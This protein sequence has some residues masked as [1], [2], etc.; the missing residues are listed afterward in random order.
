MLFDSLDLQSHND[1]TKLPSIAF[2]EKVA[3]LI[4]ADYRA[5]GII[6]RSVSTDI[7]TEIHF[8]DNI[9]DVRLPL[10]FVS[11]V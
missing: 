10:W 8:S 9:A 7:V 4:T 11:I 3:D 1:S 6:S 5:C 2:D